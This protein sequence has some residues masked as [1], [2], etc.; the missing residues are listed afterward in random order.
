[1]LPDQSIFLCVEI[2]QHMK[3]KNVCVSSE[4]N[5]HIDSN[6]KSAAMQLKKNANFI[7]LR[8]GTILSSGWRFIKIAAISPR[9]SK[10]QNICSHCIKFILTTDVLKSPGGLKKW[11]DGTGL[12]QITTPLTR[13][14]FY[15][16]FQ[17]FFNR[18]VNLSSIRVVPSPFYAWNNIGGNVQH[19]IGAGYTK[20]D[21]R[22]TI[23][24][25]VSFTCRHNAMKVLFYNKDQQTLLTSDIWPLALFLCDFGSGTSLSI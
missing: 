25:E 2:K 4:M 20:Q 1:M 13:N 8:H 14:Q 10:P 24:L 11:W 5:T 17:K 9:V 19:H 22:Y 23:K 21:G 7:S 6:L 18:F 12:S 15:V 16:D 3:D